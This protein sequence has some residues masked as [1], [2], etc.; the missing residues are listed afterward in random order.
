MAA[1]LGVDAIFV[2]APESISELEAV[3]KAVPNVVRVA[4]MVE[5]GRTP[6]LT[7]AE[8][9]E[10]GYDLIVSPLTALFTAA[11]AMRETLELLRQEGA[12][13]EHRDRLLT[14]DE[15]NAIVDLQAQYETEA[16]YS[17]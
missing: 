9:H 2:E 12:L 17:D 13:R 14:L 11:K 16:A 8:L 3:A 15:F 4:N 1:D 10:L 7:P 6:L 5:A